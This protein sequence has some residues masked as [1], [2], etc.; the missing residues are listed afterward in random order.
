MLSR[1]KLSLALMTACLIPTV[2]L[3][4][5]DFQA[6]VYTSIAAFLGGAIGSSVSSDN[7]GAGLAIG[8]LISGGLTYWLTNEFRPAARFERAQF[9]IRLAETNKLLSAAFAPDKTDAYRDAIERTYLSSQYPL[10]R[11]FD[12]LN[13]LNLSVGEADELL[14]KAARDSRDSFL[15]ER[16]GKAQDTVSVLSGKIADRMLWIKGLDAYLMQYDRMR[17][18][19]IAA[20]KLQIDRDRANAELSKANAAHRK[21][22][23]E[24]DRAAADVTDRKSTRLNSSH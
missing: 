5:T 14:D 4:I 19:Q 16:I 8:A 13:G 18:G 11:A 3:P 23:A 1:F 2:A 10:V 9:E 12:R 7:H 15:S 21:A 22:S 17:V 24:Q 6:N 20:E